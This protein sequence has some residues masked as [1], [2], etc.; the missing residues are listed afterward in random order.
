MKGAIEVVTR[1]LAKEL[2]SPRLRVNVV[3]AGLTLNVSKTPAECSFRSG[4][5]DVSVVTGDSRGRGE[6]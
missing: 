5:V 2:G 6:F 3:A 4:D 1:Y